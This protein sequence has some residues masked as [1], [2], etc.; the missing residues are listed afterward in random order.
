MKLADLL[1]LF[2][3]QA[4]VANGIITRE[5]MQMLLKL[6]DGTNFSKLRIFVSRASGFGHQANTITIIKRFIDLGF[7][8]GIEVIYDA[9]SDQETPTTI[10]KLA[11][12][13]PGLNPDEPEPY[14]LDGV[15]LTFGKYIEN[16]KVAFTEKVLLCVNGGAENNSN[17]CSSFNVDFYL[18]LQPFGWDHSDAPNALWRMGV[19]DPVSLTEVPELGKGLLIQ[20]AFYVKIPPLNPINWQE[21]DQIPGI[22]GNMLARAR[23]ICDCFLPQPSREIDFYPIYGLPVGEGRQ[24]IPG[25]PESIVFVSIVSAALAQDTRQKPIV[26]SILSTVEE[27]FFA[28]LRQ[29]FSIHKLPFDVSDDSDDED[30]PENPTRYSLGRKLEEQARQ[31]VV[32]NSITIDSP[33]HPNRIVLMFAPTGIELSKAIADATPDTIIITTLRNTPQ[34]LY[35]HLFEIATLPSIFEGQGTANYVL[36]SGKPYFQ[37]AKQNINPYPSG[38]LV[39]HLDSEVTGNITEA[40][41][42]IL[43]GMSNMSTVGENPAQ[44]LAALIT[45]CLTDGSRSANY[46][47]RVGAF[48]HA[49]ENDKLL[50][51]L[52]WWI[53]EYRPAIDDEQNFLEEGVLVTL[54]DKLKE[55]AASA[56]GVLDLLAVL[57]QFKQNDGTQTVINYLSGIIGSQVLKIGAQS[58]GV[59]ITFDP[60][61]PEDGVTVTGKTSA[62][63]NDT[64]DLKLIFRLAVDHI[65]LNTNLD[66][67]IG[68][69]NLPGVEWFA[70][71]NTKIVAEI[72]GDG[73]RVNGTANIKV[74]FGSTDADFSL[75]FPF[76]KELLAFESDF[77]AAPPDLNKLFEVLGGV[78]F[79]NTF[80]E[81]IKGITKTGLKG[82]KFLFNFEQK[83]IESFNVHLV[84]EPATPWKLAGKLQLSSLDMNVSVTD[85]SGL[86]KISWVAKSSFEIGGGKIEVNISY[87]KLSITALLEEGQ[88]NKIKLGDLFT[89][90]LSEDTTLDVEA[91]L[92]DFNFVMNPSEDQLPS[93]Y[94]LNAA[95]ESDEWKNRK[96]WSID[97]G[98]HN[99][100]LD[101]IEVQIE[102]NGN[103]KKER[104]TIGYLLATVG[105]FGSV[106]DPRDAVQMN[107]T[108]RYLSQEKGWLF[109]AKQGDK[110]FEIIKIIGTYVNP[111]WAQGDIPKLNLEGLLFQIAT[112]GTV[113]EGNSYLFAG[114]ISAWAD[115]P[116]GNL[117][118]GVRGEFGYF[119]SGENPFGNSVSVATPAKTT[120]QNKLLQVK[121]LKETDPKEPVFQAFV[122]GTMNWH[123]I[124][125]KVFFDYKKEIQKFGIEW[126]G[127]LG[128]IARKGEE[129]EAKLTFTKSTTVG[130]IVETMVSWATGTEF[131]LGAP[132]NLL[133]KISLDNL[134]LVYTFKRVDGKTSDGKVSLNVNIGPLDLGF[135]TIKG[136]KLSYNN[137]QEYLSGFQDTS[138]KEVIV[139]L[140]GS[141]F[142]QVGE[143]LNPDDPIS[144][145]AADPKSTK[146]PPGGGN[147]YFDLRY[148]GMGQHITFKGITEADTIQKA[149]EVMSASAPP[150]D[151]ELPPVQFD[152]AS[153]WLIGAD[154]GILKL[155]E[156]KEGDLAEEDTGYFIT[157]Q[158]V[159][160]DPHLYG[161]RLALAGKPAKILKELDFQIMYR[162]ISETVGV[163]QSE[164]T[165]PEIMRRL[166]IGAYTIVLPVF[167][168]AVY[169]N[170]D[171]QVDVGFPWNEDFA[172]SLTVEALIPPGIPLLGSAGFYFG[173]LSSE[174]S[175][176]VPAAINGT[177]NPVIVFGFG[178]QV[179]LGKTFEAG[180]LSA[181]FS[182]TLLAI[183]E[184]IIAKWN[185]YVLPVDTGNDDQVQG[186]Y[187]FYLSG[188]LGIAGKLYGYVDFAVIKA[189][190]NIALALLAQII[191]ESFE[192]IV[193][194][195]FAKVSATATVVINLG[196]FK[197][198]LNFSFAL[199]VKQTMYIENGGT[200]PWAAAGIQK[201]GILRQSL[202]E[203]LYALR[204]SRRR[205]FLNKSTMVPVWDNLLPP[206]AQDKLMGYAGFAATLAGE[207]VAEPSGQQV[208][209]IATLV[210]STDPVPT[211]AT[212]NFGLLKA[213]GQ[214]ED[215]AFDIFAKRVL[216]WCIAAAGDRQ[217]TIAE[218]LETQVTESMIKDMLAYLDTFK[219]TPT[220]IPADKIEAFLSAQFIIEASMPAASSEDRHGCY[221]PMPPMLHFKASADG[222]PS[223][224]GFEYSYGAYNSLSPDYLK[225]LREYFDEI[226]V[227]VRK[228]DKREM[229]LISFDGEKGPSMS[230]FIMTDYFLLV[231]RHMLRGLNSGL[232]NFILPIVEGQ[233]VK[234][235]LNA[236]NTNAGNIEPQFTAFDLFEDN[237]NHELN[238]N[239]AT[240]IPLKIGGGQFF[241]ITAD[242]GLSFQS[243]ARDIYN[244]DFTG[245]QLAVSNSKNKIIMK[246]VKIEADFHGKKDSYTTNAT[247]SLDE[248]AQGLSLNISQLLRNSDLLTMEEIF[249]ADGTA[250]LEL[251]YYKMY[252]IANA[253][254]F[255]S[256]AETQPFGKTGTAIAELNATEDVLNAGTEIT[257][258][259][260]GTTL[261]Y[262]VQPGDSLE[263]IAW[264]LGDGSLSISM[265]QLFD[266]SDVLTNPLLLKVTAELAI[267]PF[268]YNRQAGDT[269][270]H[271]AD[272]FSIGIEL[273]AD[274]IANLSIINLFSTEKQKNLN[275][276]H[277]KQYKFSELLNELQRSGS[278]EQLAAM[279]SRYYFHSLRLPTDGVTPEKAGMWVVDKD[280]A[281]AY[282][283]PEAGFFALSGQQFPVPEL[284]EGIGSFTL[285]FD[286]ADCPWLTFP[287]TG[288][289]AL[290]TITPQVSTD[291]TYQNFLEIKSLLD[292]AKA[293]TVFNSGILE[294]IQSKMYSTELVTYAF[295]QP[296][297]WL[298]GNKFVLPYNNGLEIK[299]N[300]L[301]LWRLPDGLLNLIGK[302]GRN[303]IPHFK[304]LRGAY[305]QAS[306]KT[307]STNIEQYAWSTIFKVT[308][309][310]IMESKSSPNTKCTYE[311]LGSGGN[312]LVL[313]DT[314]MRHL[315]LLD[316]NISDILVT[317]GSGDTSSD[318]L[319][320]QSDDKGV[321]TTGVSKTNLTTDSTPPTL[322]RGDIFETPGKGILN[323]PKSDFIKLI[324]EASITRSGGFY[325]YYFNHVTGSGLSDNIFN[326]KNEATLYINVIYTKP[327]AES[328]Q[329]RLYPFINQFITG[330]TF[331]LSK[332]SVFARGVP[333]EVSIG[334]NDINLSQLTLE[335]LKYIYVG[336]IDDIASRNQGQPLRPQTENE[337]FL[338]IPAGTFMVSPL[339]GPRTLTAIATRFGVNA[340]EIKKANKHIGKWDGDLPDY[341][342]LRLPT[343]KFQVKPGGLN[344]L[345]SIA[346]FY[347][348]NVVALAWINVKIPGIFDDT[349][350]LSFSA[351]APT[352]DNPTVPAGVIPYK[353]TRGVP[354]AVAA[355]LDPLNYALEYLPWVYSMFGFRI[356]ENVDFIRSNPGLP[357]GPANDDA[358]TGTSDKVNFVRD[359]NEGELWHY[360]LAL[361]YVDCIKQYP[362]EQ[363]PDLSPYAAI[364]R[365]LQVEFKWEDLFGNKIISDIDRPLP[366]QNPATL[367]RQ[368]VIAP[369]TDPIVGLGKWPA[370]SPA[371]ILKKEKPS[372][373]IFLTLLINFDTSQYEGL[374]KA[375]VTDDKKVAL[376][377]TIALDPASA[378]KIENYSISENIE[379]S[380]AEYEETD[381]KVILDVT[382]LSTD[383]I[384]EVFVKGISTAESVLRPKLINGDATFTL[385]EGAPTSSGLQIKSEQDLV[386]Y[387]ALISQLSDPNGIQLTIRA[388]ILNGEIKA[389][390]D[391]KDDLIA[392][393][394]TLADFI[395]SRSSGSGSRNSPEPIF[396]VKHPVREDDINIEE[397]QALSLDFVI[398]R[399]KRIIAPGM[400]PKSGILESV[401]G[402]NPK[403][404]D[405]PKDH[406]TQT[407]ALSR[408]AKDFEDA[409]NF[410]DFRLKVAI[411]VDRTM[412][413]TTDSGGVVWIVKLGKNINYG[414]SCTVLNKDKPVILAPSPAAN[415]L[416]SG[417]V[418]IRKYVPGTILNP[419]DPEPP[420]EVIVMADIDVD[421][422][423]ARFL[424]TI[425]DILSPEFLSSMQ[426]LQ[427]LDPRAGNI[428][429][430]LLGQKKELARLAKGSLILFYEDETDDEFLT[431][432][433]DVFEQQLL[434]SLTNAYNTRAAMQFRMKVNA[435]I[436]ETGE[437]KHP[438]FFGPVI[439]RK[440]GRMAEEEIKHVEVHLS[441]P[442][443]TLESAGKLPLSIML[444]GPSVV[445]GSG[446]EVVPYM[447]LNLSYQPSFIEHQIGD[448]YT[449]EGYRP[450]SWLNFII[451]EDTPEYE[452]G[453]FI[454]PSYLRAFPV[455]P[456]LV[457]HGMTGD[458]TPA[459]RLVD[460]IS[461]IIKWDYYFTY[462][463]GM[464][465]PHDTINC[466]VNFNVPNASGEDASVDNLFEPLAQFISVQNAVYGDIEKNLFPLLPTTDASDPIVGSASTALLSMKNIIQY[467]IDGAQQ[468]K[469][470]RAAAWQPPEDI[471]ATLSY[472][473]T[474]RESSEVIQQVNALLVVIET[475]IPDDMGIAVVTIAG[476]AEKLYE[477]YPTTSGEGK[478]VFAYYYKKQGSG[479]ILTAREGQE[480]PERTVLIKDIDI[481]KRQN[482]CATISVK[483][484]EYTRY[485][486][487]SRKAAEPF[488]YNSGF[489]R[490]NAP[491]Y[492]TITNET[493]IDIANVVSAMT[494]AG[495]NSLSAILS[496]FFMAL[497]KNNEQDEIIIQLSVTYLFSINDS[498]KS[499][500][501][502]PL[503]FNPPEKVSGKPVGIN[504]LITKWSN[505]ILDRWLRE[506]NPTN[507][508]A[509][510][511]K[512]DLTIMSDSGTASRTYALLHLP[513]LILNISDISNIP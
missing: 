60:L 242:R 49:E 365:L 470:L 5:G 206:A 10:Q 190:V 134:E 396:S 103:E 268:D 179:G 46:F 460:S 267:P 43:F 474:I 273:L 182:L 296:G 240:G 355:R 434:E 94:L 215:K 107:L 142:W 62:F 363:E 125:L 398:A 153:N 487:I 440:P 34:I 79:V 282:T 399:E 178:F 136:F 247:E 464:H 124:D 185:P 212:N 349:A 149:I 201:A 360:D 8:K 57:E 263:D 172:R 255:N 180:I 112:G 122:E 161:L 486:E 65:K 216:L 416:K 408:F 77:G 110:P 269:L 135:A 275:I 283:I 481:I 98:N 439:Q 276:A 37:L 250:K 67:T 121:G 270:T 51:V 18:Q 217:V 129:Y 193:F 302:S 306:G 209:Y 344:T 85:P 208:C 357:V 16:K 489:V 38:A 452:L 382:A 463:Q 175:D 220:P 173:K 511:L 225:R 479:E 32:D 475:T 394:R 338:T 24:A 406:N 194:T 353:A 174:T 6:F 137:G 29:L 422:W 411:G 25:T 26:I 248:I 258:T 421:T 448:P 72:P 435:N 96:V 224:K 3:D 506:H 431:D 140:E 512:F 498:L 309:K 326:D 202:D 456:D 433:Q 144:W 493:E 205:H 316:E 262:I 69:F 73:N 48:Y 230:E 409:C 311:I 312:D 497:L 332:Y 99:F 115:T 380:A 284:K 415:A 352:T 192:P 75:A 89:F 328:K 366:T 292:F 22:D 508:K 446:G 223:Y 42:K 266:F 451:R 373:E 310:K 228:E 166:T 510:T 154:F 293:D 188:T 252:I 402:V 305:N 241:T 319:Y 461:D 163:Y 86:R 14:I 468:N 359:L 59:V 286:A 466:V 455:A 490:F 472:G 235:V 229:S 84:N 437:E 341:L 500:V 63:A 444:S 323:V 207:E 83:K 157:A 325:L 214:A 300:Q 436:R 410:K 351:A 458:D 170:G 336:N 438:R 303:A 342:G 488:V 400:G 78:D 238:P 44:S 368:P 285:S 495:R 327:S 290:F 91:S 64:L 417:E 1:R 123:G 401:T 502:V 245:F 264:G 372:D 97:I 491:L 160:N 308:V 226:A 379:I 211:G 200:K 501:E 139:T 88:E 158:I 256:I 418:S 148:L 244:Q 150:T 197:I 299:Y 231:A 364:G 31:W 203:R 453:E 318:R 469:G 47:A 482:A 294:L 503:L 449:P 155:E 499:P 478:Q 445:K 307:D 199:D 320:L 389:K 138:G 281:Y 143:G 141:F 4:R 28:G 340:E 385:S 412:A 459:A 485:E 41:Y 126:N 145:N 429:K 9:T 90:F 82:L 156:K 239:D 39:P 471:Q 278:I 334:S 68:N 162:Q 13:L 221:F 45:E 12:L 347:G 337:R 404:E 289:I 127:L 265:Q 405:L 36:N 350:V 384:Y 388:S 390:P 369:Y 184:G 118:A 509:G 375:E 117:S 261:T 330:E 191:Y 55:N 61:K 432:A 253:D 442:K 159:F 260:A 467:V 35:N 2:D 66:L 119:A 288:K 187:Y 186:Q 407:L 335:Q 331:D 131:G 106:A 274:N 109:I 348:I 237:A 104:D 419:I 387:A 280:N 420:K 301:Q 271:I 383:M 507:V 386:A 133:S 213:T 198:R 17:L 233:S 30:E 376:Y 370:V 277:L 93:S 483:R 95:L 114:K 7:T 165:L 333:V 210:L 195:V 71:N 345:Q 92:T 128:Y 427:V 164:I 20:R 392:W 496:N 315:P 234:D 130:S 279:L 414:I 425:D 108:A 346:G 132:W 393:V 169:T 227:Q 11:I 295:S 430:E 246:G 168:V 105:L 381:N 513:N 116:L 457:S 354:K 480:L 314:M 441:S 473:F 204:I 361:K 87:P 395:G 356:A 120:L 428:I 243:I 111:E 177:F 454:V 54:Y 476:Y 189:E 259:D 222:Y 70:L 147:K 304:V 236:V 324:W 232:R 371:W 403:L 181:G 218:L 343:V 339:G 167:A 171:F 196:L 297:L 56:G 151:K 287:P 146:A 397:I 219:E 443:L 15:V 81:P 494:E 27:G 52:L 362:E 298:S 176:K 413:T 102:S 367:N 391:I 100:S 424:M 272:I 23:V 505:A 80:P 19:E 257:Y 152:A 477:G 504:G 183:I 378:V 462:A 450:S 313:L 329:D 76:M 254:T 50:M 374:L 484:N 40:V 358:H 74:K 33:D 322:G 21:L 113:A 291:P 101:R 321:I 377:F 447:L 426:V 251:P 53:A 317:F 249:V 492:P 465:Y 423:L 58:D